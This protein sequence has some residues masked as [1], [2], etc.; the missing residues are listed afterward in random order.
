MVLCSCNVN[1]VLRSF[2][3]FHTM[4]GDDNH[5]KF[6]N[7]VV[8]YRDHCDGWGAKYIFI[9]GENSLVVIS[10]GQDSTINTSDDVFLYEAVKR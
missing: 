6:V 4:E 3:D 2:K 1:C 9:L 5:D 7:V 10:K 8:K